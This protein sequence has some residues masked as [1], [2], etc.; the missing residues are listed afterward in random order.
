MMVFFLVLWLLQLLQACFLFY[1]LLA[2]LNTSQRRCLK[3][4]HREK[5]ALKESYVEY[6]SRP[7][8]GLE[9]NTSSD[10]LFPGFQMKV[11]RSSRVL[12]SAQ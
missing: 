1:F 10:W 4:H 12:L 5:K 8:Q 11:K 9:V 3:V 7:Q 2:P 6:P